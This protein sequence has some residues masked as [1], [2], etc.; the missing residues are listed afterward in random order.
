MPI[1]LIRSTARATAATR[2]TRELSDAAPAQAQVAINVW[3]R[4]Y[5]RVR[6]HYA[7]NM[8]PPVPETL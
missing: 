8:R 2:H 4:Q 7:L 3:L 6:P 5:N 1:L